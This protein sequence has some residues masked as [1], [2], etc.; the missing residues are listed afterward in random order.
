MFAILAYSLAKKKKKMGFGDVGRAI[1]HNNLSSQN[2]VATS[3][4]S[5]G[6]PTGHFFPAQNIAFSD[7]AQTFTKNQK[8][9]PQFLTSASAPLFLPISFK[10]SLIT[11][12]YRS[13]YSHFYHSLWPQCS[14][15][16]RL[17]SLQYQAFCPSTTYPITLALKENPP[18]TLAIIVYRFLPLFSFDHLLLGLHIRLC[19][20]P[21]FCDPRYPFSFLR[22]FYT[23][24]F[25]QFV[26]GH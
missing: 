8:T 14:Q 19:H 26:Q 10:K 25:F 22:N 3:W 6:L 21:E 17:L 9:F 20:S 7:I 4:V 13:S 15:C 1:T 2:I 23:C 24:Q 11:K 12:I 16:P 5:I 18:G